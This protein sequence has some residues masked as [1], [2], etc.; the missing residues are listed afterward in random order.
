MKKRTQKSRIYELIGR[1]TVFL[2]VWAISVFSLINLSLYVL[3][4]CITTIR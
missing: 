2:I 3:N 4:N 1:I